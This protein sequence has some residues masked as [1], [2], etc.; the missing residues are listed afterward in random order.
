M[1]VGVVGR[2]GLFAKLQGNERNGRCLVQDDRVFNE[3]PNLNAF[4]LLLPEIQ[5]CRS[6]IASHFPSGSKST[7]SK[8]I[9]LS[10]VLGRL[11]QINTGSEVWHAVLMVYE[12]TSQPRA[13]YLGP[14]LAN[15][16]KFICAVVEVQITE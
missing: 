2:A 11:P 1:G 7:S 10:S 15:D 5:S 3:S 6:T 14:P 16:V 8:C 13:S 4:I 12:Y 9:F